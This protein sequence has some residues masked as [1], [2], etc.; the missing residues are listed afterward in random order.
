MLGAPTMF[1]RQGARAK[2]WKPLQAGPPGSTTPGRSAR[3]PSAAGVSRATPVLGHLTAPAT[4]APAHGVTSITVYVAGSVPKLRHLLRSTSRAFLCRSTSASRS[5]VALSA[6][7]AEG[8]PL[9]AA[10]IVVLFGPAIV[11]QYWHP[12]FLQSSRIAYPEIGLIAL[13]RLLSSGCFLG[14]RCPI[15]SVNSTP[16]ESY[17]CPRSC[18]VAFGIGITRVAPSTVATDVRASSSLPAPWKARASYVRDHPTSG[19]STQAPDADVIGQHRHEGKA[20]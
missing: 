14:A 3:A 15:A 6:Y 10:I 19:A 8:S 17:A 4:S 20:E 12:L 1:E 16:A 18:L 5:A 11:I 9:P 7:S 2:M 13:F